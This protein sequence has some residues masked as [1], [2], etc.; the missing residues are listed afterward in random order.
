MVMVVDVFHVVL[1]VVHVFL[2]RVGFV[3]VVAPTESAYRW[4]FRCDQRL[5]WLP[6]GLPAL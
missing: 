5:V 3:M 6:P 1:H 4:N 2:Q